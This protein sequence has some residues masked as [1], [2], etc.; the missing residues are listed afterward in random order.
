VRLGASGIG[1]AKTANSTGG[2]APDHLLRLFAYNHILQQIGP[3][4]FCQG[5]IE[6]E[7][8]AEAA[9][10]NIVSP[11]SSLIVLETQADYERFDIQKSKDSL[12][13]ASMNASGA[14]PE[15]E[16]WALIIIALL[17]V[18]FVTLKPYFLR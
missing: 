2:S 17:A 10:A 11:V 1:I 6:D 3:R 14:V 13:N 9:Q 7:L 18:G 15:P 16:E 5:D 4:Y 8:I 12:G